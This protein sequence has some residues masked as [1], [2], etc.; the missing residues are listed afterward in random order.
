MRAGFVRAG[1]ARRGSG[2]ARPGTPTTAGLS[3]TAWRDDGEELVE[4]TL[5]APERDELP[6]VE[7]ERGSMPGLDEHPER[8]LGQR[9]R[10]V[11][12]TLVQRLPR[13]DEVRHAL[14]DPE[15]VLLADRAGPF[16]G[17]VRPAGVAALG[18]A[19][20]SRSRPSPARSGHRA[21]SASATFSALFARRMGSVC[22]TARR[23]EVLVEHERQGRWV[24]DPPG[25]AQR[26]VGDREGGRGQPRRRS[27]AP[28]SSARS[29]SR[30]ARSMLSTFR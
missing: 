27:N 9:F 22:G 10:V 8:F 24:V 2:I 6:R 23:L 21:A 19:D 13:S 12:P 26:V 18:P 16:E 20:Q 15:A 5:V 28:R 4:A 17:F 25:H 7:R 1:R 30:R 29:A 14:E 11:Q 3:A